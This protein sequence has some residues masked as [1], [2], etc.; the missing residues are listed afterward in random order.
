MEKSGS[1]VTSMSYCLS[2]EPQESSLSP[3]HWDYRTHPVYPTY[4]TN[5]AVCPAL[6]SLCI[7]G[8]QCDGCVHWASFA[9]LTWSCLLVRSNCSSFKI[10]LLHTTWESGWGQSLRKCLHGGRPSPAAAS[11]THSCLFENFPSFPHGTKWLLVL[12]FVFNFECFHY[13]FKVFFLRIQEQL[14]KHTT[15]KSRLDFD[16][17]CCNCWGRWAWTGK[18]T[19]LHGKRGHPSHQT[20][21]SILWATA[22]ANNPLEVVL[23]ML[24]CRHLHLSFTAFWG[25]PFVC[26]ATA[27]ETL[28]HMISRIDKL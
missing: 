13:K 20:S 16:K 27:I 11:Q 12:I 2:L 17:C 19:L 3:Q 25:N 10:N 6:S 5:P 8:Y 9:T 24:I 1:T 4:F 28:R 18:A 21:S 14:Y 22:M 26:F 15:F 23:K 7:R